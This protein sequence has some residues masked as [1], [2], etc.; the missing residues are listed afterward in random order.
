MTYRYWKT[1]EPPRAILQRS[2]EAALLLVA[3]LYPGVTVSSF[4]A[5]M[6][7]RAWSGG[8]T[9]EL[10]GLIQAAV[11]ELADGQ[12]ELAVVDIEDLTASGRAVLRDD[13]WVAEGD[14]MDAALDVLGRDEQRLAVPPADLAHGAARG[15]DGRQH[16]R[17]LRH[18]LVDAVTGD[19]DGGCGVVGRVHRCLLVSCVDSMPTSRDSP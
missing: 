3:Y 2:P 17:G 10:V 13:R 11:G 12:A 5:A 16:L 18:A 4:G 9:G 6:I 15:L 1:D 14:P 8:D 19:P 7:A